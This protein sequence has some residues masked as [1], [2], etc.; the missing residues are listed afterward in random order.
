MERQRAKA[1]RERLNLIRNDFKVCELKGDFWIVHA[2][3]AIERFEPDTTSTD[4]ARRL[5]A[6]RNTATKYYTL[7]HYESQD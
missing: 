3:L 5:E 2:G 1:E 4:M 7:K 6:I